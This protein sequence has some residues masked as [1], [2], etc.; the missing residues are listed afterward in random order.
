MENHALCIKI[1][2]EIFRMQKRVQDMPD[3]TKGIEPVKNSLQRLE[4]TLSENGYQIINLLDTSYNEGMTVNARFVPKKDLPIGE[5]R[6]IRVI[7]PQI[8]FNG[9]LIRLA[10]VEVGIS[11]LTDNQE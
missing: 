8:N 6:I 10:D 7:R 11:E 9:V 5:E 1:A 2:D 4:D 3:Q